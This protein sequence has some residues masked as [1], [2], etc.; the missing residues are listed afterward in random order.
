MSVAAAGI[1]RVSSRFWKP[2]NQIE[3]VNYS[4]WNIQGYE[5]QTNKKVPGV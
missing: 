4:I 5:E 1:E 3:K 2:Y